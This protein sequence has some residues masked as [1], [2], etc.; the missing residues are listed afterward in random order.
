MAQT[1]G[2]RGSLGQ[3]IVIGFLSLVFA[4]LFYWLLNFITQDIGRRPGP[5]YVKV[6]DQYVDPSLLGQQRQIMEN[7]ESV[8]DQLA[9]QTRQRDLLRDSTQSL[10]TTINQLLSIQEQSIKSGTAL[11]EETRKHID[12]SLPQ[13]LDNQKRYEKFNQE[14]ADLTTQGN[15][16]EK[17]LKELNRKIEEQR[18]KGQAEYNDLYRQYRLKTAAYQLLVVIPIFL[19]GSWLFISYRTGFYGPLVWASFWAVFVKLALIVH[20]YFPREYFKYIAL[21]VILAIVVWLLVYLLKGLAKPRLAV[22]MRQRRQSYGRSECPVCGTYL[23]S[24]QA[25]RTESLSGRN[26]PA[27]GADVPTES[28]YHCPGCGTALYGKCGSCGQIR[29]LMLPFCRHCGAQKPDWN[30]V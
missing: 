20:A 1:V 22:L 18:Q 24:A 11:T 6:Q 4:V 3:R 9:A 5:D 10:Q 23:L 12:S 17:Q 2:F 30:I 16:L 7:I 29:H 26:T 15:N 14:I 13:F 27:G 25:R 19:I 21:A 28:A 8:K